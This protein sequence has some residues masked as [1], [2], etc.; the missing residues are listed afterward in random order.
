MNSKIH[1]VIPDSHARP[2]FNNDRYEWLGNLINDVK[3]DVVIDIGDWYDMESLSSYD[4]GKKAFEGR[5]Y[6]KDIDS[7]LEAQDRLLSTI[8]KQKRKLPRFVRTLGNHENRINKM[9]NL[10]PEFEGVLSMSD[11]QSKE[12]NWEEVEF[13]VPIVIDGIHYCHHFPSGAMGK[14]IGGENIGRMLLQKKHVSCTQGHSHLF[15]YAVRST[16]DGNKIMGLS[17]G[18]FFDYEMD[19]AGPV[20][21]LYDRGVVIKR[22]VDGGRY[23]LEWVS[24]DRLKS[25]YGTK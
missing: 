16:M 11:L 18:C 3:P 19:Y 7:G 21:A 8:K 22:N 5:R 17:V 15:D 2:G 14:P 4:K 10:S 24:M 12:Y 13:N 23:D 9:I 25:E 1:I 20:N 6:K